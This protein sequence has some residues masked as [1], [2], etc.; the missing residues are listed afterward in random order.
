MEN[1]INNLIIKIGELEDKINSLN[2]NDNEKK[3]DKDGNNFNDDLEKL[4]THDNQIEESKLYK[5]NNNLFK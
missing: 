1:K 2:K 4:K 3:D 5:F